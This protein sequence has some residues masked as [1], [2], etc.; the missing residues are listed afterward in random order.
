MF[1]QRNKYREIRNRIIKKIYRGHNTNGS[2]RVTT[3]IKKYLQYAIPALAHGHPMKIVR[4]VRIELVDEKPAEYDKDDHL[5][6]FQSDKLY[7]HMFSIKFTFAKF[8]H[9]HKFYPDEEFREILRA[10]IESD[11]VFELAKS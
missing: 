8:H 5:R 3:I 1:G 2:L 11:N 7:G 4:T 9:E 6:C 10:S